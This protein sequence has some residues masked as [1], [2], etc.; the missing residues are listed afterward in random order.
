MPPPLNAIQLLDSIAVLKH[1]KMGGRGGHGI[2]TVAVAVVDMRLRPLHS[3]CDP[4]RILS[5]SAHL[6]TSTLGDGVA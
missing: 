1:R 5:G 2:V 3:E 6:L 4:R